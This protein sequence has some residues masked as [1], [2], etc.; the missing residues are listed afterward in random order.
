MINPVAD[1]AIT[2]ID[3]EEASR[4]NLKLEFAPAKFFMTPFKI[5]IPSVQFFSTYVFFLFT[6][7]F[8]YQNYKINL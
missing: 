8:L 5:F 2:R 3:N 7:F 1:D 6:H 4:Q